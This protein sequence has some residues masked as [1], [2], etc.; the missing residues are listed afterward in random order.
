M[1]TTT[2]SGISFTAKRF[3]LP[4]VLLMALLP[5]VNAGII[6]SSDFET[7]TAG[8][9]ASGSLPGLTRAS[10]PTDGG[11]LSSPNQSMWLGKLGDGIAKSGSQDEIVTLNLSGLTA[12][13]SYNV[14]FDLFIGASWDGSAGGYGPDSWRFAV[15]WRPARGHNL[16]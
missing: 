11:G 8:F 5:S 6:F 4:A 1:K 13:Q 16:Q 10:L 7:G 2:T 15:D 9:T 12:G 3:F 14:A